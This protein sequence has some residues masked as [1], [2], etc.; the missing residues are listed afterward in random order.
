MQLEKGPAE[1][2]VP[3]AWCHP[4]L[5]RHRNDGNGPGQTRTCPDNDTETPNPDCS[6]AKCV[7]LSCGSSHSDPQLERLIDAWATLDQTARGQIE[8]I[9]QNTDGME[10]ATD[11]A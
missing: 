10:T 4:G 8:Q 6:G 7:A 1:M 3:F 5:C 2:P 11:I 9:I